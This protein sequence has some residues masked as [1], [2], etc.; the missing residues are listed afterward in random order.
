MFRFVSYFICCS[1]IPNVKSKTMMLLQK[2]NLLEK[3]TDSVVKLTTVVQNICLAMWLY[4]DHII[5]GAKVGFLKM[6][7]TNQS[8]RSNIFWL[9]AMVCGMSKDF[10]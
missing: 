9:I 6:D 3:E 7:V 8:R 4:Y 10:V 1:C 5:L 2:Q